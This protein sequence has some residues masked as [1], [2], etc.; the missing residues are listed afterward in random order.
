MASKLVIRELGRLLTR[1]FR[2]AP[3]RRGGRSHYGRDVRG[4]A[5]IEMALIFPIMLIVFVGLIDV[6]NLMTANRRVTL[7]ASTLG[8]LV[9]QSPGSVKVADLDGFFSA[10][11]S[12]M[13][14]FPEAS[15]SLAFYTFKHDSSGAE[16]PG[17]QYSSTGS[18]PDCGDPPV[19]DDNVKNLMAENNDVV[20]S[21]TCYQWE[22]ILGI[23]LGFSTSI[24]QD[25]LMLRPRQTARIVCEDCPNQG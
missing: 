1:L 7:T 17:W 8:D 21:R 10:A 23:I 11:R 19:V 13:A 15:T 16:V 3:D 6:S 18:G 24:V 12:I 2:S 9:T 4:V 22:P 20:V 5:S 25:Q 14:P